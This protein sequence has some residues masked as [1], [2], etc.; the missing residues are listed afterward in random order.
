MRKDCRH[1]YEGRMCLESETA[2]LVRRVEV[3]TDLGEEGRAMTPS[4]Q[5]HLKRIVNTENIMCI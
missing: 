4:S 1:A 2:H 5:K 3:K